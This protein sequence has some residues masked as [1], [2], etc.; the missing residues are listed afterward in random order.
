MSILC[1]VYQSGKHF[2]FGK[3][4]SKIITCGR[5]FYQIIIFF[6]CS[7]VKNGT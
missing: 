2:I 3:K 4:F 7:R 1:A 6:V 5:V